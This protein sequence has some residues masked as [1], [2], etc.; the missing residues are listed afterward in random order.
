M[1]G[2]YSAWSIIRSISSAGRGCGL[3]SKNI[4]LTARTSKMVGSLFQGGGVGC[5]GSED[6]VEDISE[7]KRSVMEL[8]S[9]M[10]KA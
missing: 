2:Q 4:C 5:D 6:E 7:A 10:L 9:V 3:R 1:W 8:R